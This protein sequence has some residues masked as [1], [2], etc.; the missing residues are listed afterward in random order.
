MQSRPVRAE[1]PTGINRQAK[2]SAQA[3]PR[4]RQSGRKMVPYFASHRMI[5]IIVTATAEMMLP[6]YSPVLLVTIR[7]S[8][9]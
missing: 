6:S 4:T 1:V 3:K 5:G 7:F 9:P 2:T 8:S